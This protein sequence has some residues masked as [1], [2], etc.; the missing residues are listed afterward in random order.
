MEY[1]RIKSDKKEQLEKVRFISN[2]I[3]D[4]FPELKAIEVGQVFH[5]EYYGKITATKVQQHSPTTYSIYGFDE[6][7]GLPRDNYYPKDLGLVGREIMLNNVLHYFQE[8]LFEQSYMDKS[9]TNIEMILSE[10]DYSKPYL[11]DQSEA[12]IFYVFDFAVGEINKQEG[13]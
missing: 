6:K 4:K 2:V 5:S 8:L 1:K 9:K 7:D 13:L 3:R 11:K 10:W 12:T